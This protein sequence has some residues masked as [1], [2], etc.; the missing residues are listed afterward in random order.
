M[1][2]VVRSAERLSEVPWL[3]GD[4]LDVAVADITDAAATKN[5][6][7]GVMGVFHTAAAFEVS[8]LS[9]KELHR[10]NV[11]GTENVLRACA[12]HA[13]RRIVFTSSAVAVGTSGPRRELRDES[14]WNERPREIYARSKVESEKRAWE[15]SRQLGI[16]LVAVLPG[17]MLGPGFSRPTPTLEMVSGAVN[18]TFPMVPPCDFAFTDVRDVAEAHVRLY[19]TGALERYLVAGPTLSFR[20]LLQKVHELRSDVRVPDEMSPWLTRILPFFDAVSHAVTGAPRRIRSGFVAQYVGRSHVLSME[21]AK[22]AIAWSPRP[23]TTTLGDT[24]TW[25]ASQNDYSVL[26][27]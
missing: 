7:E 21:K 23:L 1:R 17:A 13:V 2:A 6:F 22:R 10:I 19:E 26:D 18:D 3:R 14:V 5:A 8:K 11:V 27:T 16:D 15:L 4:G 12:D 25:L 24:L 9:A 20:T